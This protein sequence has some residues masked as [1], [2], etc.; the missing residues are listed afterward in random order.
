M[1]NGNDPPAHIS[2]LEM[3]DDSNKYVQYM[4]PNK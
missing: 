3:S 4:W 2:C 1:N